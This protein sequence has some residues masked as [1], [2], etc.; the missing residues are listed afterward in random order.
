MKSERVGW[1]RYFEGPLRVE[2]E[3]IGNTI[4]TIAEEKWFVCYLVE[5]L[6]VLTKRTISISKAMV[7]WEPV[8]FLAEEEVLVV[9]RRFNWLASFKGPL[10]VI[11]Q[12]DEIEITEVVRGAFRLYIAIAFCRKYNHEISAP[13]LDDFCNVRC[14]YPGEKKLFVSFDGLEDEDGERELINCRFLSEKEIKKEVE[15][16]LGYC[17]SRKSFLKA[18]RARFNYSTALDLKWRRKGIREVLVNRIGRD[19]D[20]HI[21]VNIV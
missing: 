3:G 9:K 12:G 19:E 5:A 16:L 1:N 20:L 6:K 18:F 13:D 14:F 8:I 10:T 21:K 11:I 4:I 17:K 15:Y 2:V 7:I